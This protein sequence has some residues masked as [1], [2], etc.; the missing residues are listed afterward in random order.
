VSALSRAEKGE[1]EKGGI[2]RRESDVQRGL[3]AITPPVK[4]DD[5]QIR[6]RKV[7]AVTGTRD[8]NAGEC[9]A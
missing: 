1:R 3:G 5:S 6:Q 2:A 7:L 4:D 9:F 8:G